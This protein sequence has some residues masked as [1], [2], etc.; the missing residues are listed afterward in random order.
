MKL[1]VYVY[2]N[3]AVCESVL[4]WTLSVCVYHVSYLTTVTTTGA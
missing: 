3:V 2:M 4:V 1:L